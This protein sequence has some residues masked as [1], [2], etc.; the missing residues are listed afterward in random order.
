MFTARVEASGGR[1]YV[2]GSLNLKKLKDGIHGAKWEKKT[3][4]GRKL[5]RVHVPLTPHS[6]RL[7]KGQIDAQGAG[8][9]EWDDTTASLLAH[10]Y[11]TNFLDHNI[12][13]PSIPETT[14]EPWD[15]QRRAFWHTVDRWG[16]SI[17]PRAAGGAVLWLDMGCGKTK[18]AIDVIRNFAF[19]RTLIVCP[20]KVVDV[21]PEQWE[22]H[23]PPEGF[24]VEALKGDTT[25]RAHLIEQRIAGQ[26][27]PLVFVTNYE[28]FDRKPMQ[29]VAK[30][31]G[32]NC[33]ILDEMHRIK[34]P[35]G[36]RSKYFS[37][38][39]DLVPCRLG[40][41][42]TFLPNSPLDAY[43]QARFVDAS[44]FGY[45]FTRFRS[46]YAILGGYSV[47]GQPVQILGY[48][49]EEDL[50][51]SI[52]L[53]AI[54]VRAE[55][56]QDL[57]EEH[58]VDLPVVLDEATRKLYDQLE[59]EFVMLLESGEEVTAANVLVK[60]GK[61][62]EVTGGA[63]RNPD[64]GLVHKMG[65]EK[66]DLLAEKLEDLQPNDPVV[67]FARF[68]T[69]LDNCHEAARMA[70]RKSLE[71]SGTRNDLKEWQRATGGEVLV[72]QI[73]SGKE[74]IDLTRSRFAFYYSLTYQPG[75]FLQ[76]KKRQHRPGQKAERVTYFHLVAK[77]TIDEAIWKAIQKK[78]SVI[79]TVRK[80][81][82]G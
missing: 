76:S 50:G 12:S 43:A 73:S 65:T 69:D 70:G 30:D 15:H 31:A 13:V 62:Q 7:I 29:E 54:E 47:N 64:T 39:G 19:W 71:L 33:V 32:F 46:E 34:D 53:F 4:G 36:K 67:V 37:T 40:L 55:D 14:T 21:W 77:D 79:D 59:K 41:T 22:R 63:I 25:R 57:P 49:N 20:A 2:S 56:V 26:T 75:E 51:R 74:G 72:A 24:R 44:H 16:G 11:G 60:V 52:K 18:V 45:S 5:W 35:G 80:E 1:C 68:R 8:S 17:G 27:Y 28:A 38:L 61:L 23:G 10:P 6:I 3:V 58:M 81:V 82:R 48:K 66:R 78:Q 42:G 9:T